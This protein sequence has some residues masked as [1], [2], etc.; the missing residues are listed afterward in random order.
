[1]Q[2]AAFSSDLGKFIKTHVTSSKFESCVTVI[3]KQY[4][5]TPTQV[6]NWIK[7]EYQEVHVL[8]TNENQ[9]AVS[10]LIKESDMDTNAF[11]IFREQWL[12][13]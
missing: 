9:S 8:G 6:K 13:F 4:L 10:E 12:I 5:T 11:N 3:K 7:I 2:H 1:M